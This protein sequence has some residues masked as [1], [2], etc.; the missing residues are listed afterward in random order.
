MRVQRHRVQSIYIDMSAN[1]AHVDINILQPALKLKN[2][3]ISIL[4]NI[5]VKTYS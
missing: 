5:L 1:F 2:Q 3:K 4:R